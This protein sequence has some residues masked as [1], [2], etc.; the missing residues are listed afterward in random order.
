M[1]LVNRNLLQFA[2]MQCKEQD[3]VLS[4]SE[5]A[6]LFKFLRALQELILSQFGL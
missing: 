6:I 3:K 5:S 1:F 4:K 2:F